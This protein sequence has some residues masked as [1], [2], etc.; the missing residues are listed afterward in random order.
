MPATENDMTSPKDR[1]IAAPNS[2]TIFGGGIAG[3]TAA[4]EL[5]ERNFK[6]VVWE[7]GI[8]SRYP[9]AGCDVGGMARTQWAA[10]DWPDDETGGHRALPSP[11]WAHREARAVNRLP[12]TF[13]F[14]KDPAKGGDEVLGRG[15]LAFGANGPCEPET[16]IAE[17]L[18]R[19]A[20]NPSIRRVYCEVQQREDGGLDKAL[21]DRSVAMVE[22]VLARDKSADLE[23]TSVESRGAS[24]YVFQVVLKLTL[25]SRGAGRGRKPKDGE[26]TVDLVVVLLEGFP[27]D[28]PA[29]FDMRL[30]LRIRE[31]WLP[32][33][34]GFRFFPSFYAHLFDTMKRT[35]ILEP[36]AKS[37]VALAQERS[38]TVNPDGV[39]YAATGQTAYDHLRP[40]SLMAFGVRRGAPVAVESRSA[41]A[42]LEDIRQRLLLLFKPQQDGMGCTARDV[43]LLFLKTVKYLTTCDERRNE[44][45]Q[46][47]WMDFLGGES[48]YSPAFVQMANRWPEALV[49]M[50]AKTIDARTQGSVMMQLVLD[51][52]RAP[53]YRDGTLIGPTSDA[54]LKYWRRYLEDQG[55]EFVHGKLDGFRTVSR[56]GE[57]FVWPKVQCY[58]PQYPMDESGQPDLAPG[59]FVLALPAVQAQE[60]AKA[61]LAERKGIERLDGAL[62][63]VRLKEMDLG[64]L[65]DP[66][67]SQLRN[68]VGIQYYL[69]DD[70][71]WFDGHM[72]WPDSKWEI[73]GLSQTYFW[74]DRP[75]WE[76]GYRGLMSVIFSTTRD[77]KLDPEILASTPAELAKEVWSQ[78]RANLPN[79]PEPRHWHIDDNFKETFK[80]GKKGGAR[81]HASYENLSPYLVNVAG[82]WDARPGRL[83]KLPDLEKHAAEGPGA[84]DL[85]EKGY[86]VFDGIVFAGTHM[87]TFTRLTTMEAA[88]ES[89]R[90]AVNGVLHDREKAAKAAGHTEG[91]AAAMHRR[92][93]CSIWP[94]EE[95]EIEDFL[96]LK[97]LDKELYDR[98]LDHFIDILEL[99]QL[100]AHGLKGGPDDPFD[101]MRV[102]TE[103][104]RIC[105]DYGTAIR[106]AI[107]AMAG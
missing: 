77:G 106:D 76:H 49:A 83:A 45:E 32:G 64:S 13:V 89:G 2:V 72:Y 23:V 37:T 66:E 25:R 26:R 44:Y 70:V 80:D 71:T 59:Y 61:Y 101:K 63:F 8:D 53:G 11:S 43:T 87:K 102:L 58:D 35:P 30:T 34:H 62:D 84:G 95:R 94:L 57:S 21:I 65:D 85:G 52:V 48:S 28:V 17:F 38:V 56:G 107:E 81:E 20:D 100:A 29:D 12:Q 3:L 22:A 73:T 86:R 75:D 14:F 36:V 79:A 33:E 19:V 47:T 7:P 6:V 98:G 54:W 104:G 9:D 68:M 55:V 5:V 16:A 74:R 46:M 41:P 4:H 93:R 40:T 1:N 15:V 42:S 39:K 31:R 91:V 18:E 103:L 27:G 67:Q 82:K 10:V 97:E 105:G 99:D 69:E 51:M 96:F 88:N 92:S 24:G 60:M 78:V 90:H 50:D